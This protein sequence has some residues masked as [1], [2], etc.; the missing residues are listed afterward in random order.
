MILPMNMATEGKEVEVKAVS[1]KDD[2]GKRLR[3]LGIISGNKV[4][5]V[6]NDGRNLIISIQESRFALDLDAAR[7]IMI[8]D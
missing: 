2:T 7:Q 5:I 1:L 3:E 8:S 4:K 6:K